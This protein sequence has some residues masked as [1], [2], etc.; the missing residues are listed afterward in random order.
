[1]EMIGPGVKRRSFSGRLSG[2][3]LGLESLSTEADIAQTS[4]IRQFAS[5][6]RPRRRNNQVPHAP[7]LIVTL[8]VEAD[9]SLIKVSSDAPAADVTLAP[10]TLV[11]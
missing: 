6:E 1:M 4:S 3:P 5:A 10:V 9:E 7:E 11:Q 8:T 2:C